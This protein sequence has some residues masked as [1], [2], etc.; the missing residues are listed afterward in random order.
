MLQEHTG[1]R[2]ACGLASASPS[3]GKDFL[4]CGGEA[5]PVCGDGSPGFP[6]VSV[7]GRRVHRGQW[8]LGSCLL[9]ALVGI[10]KEWPNVW[11][12]T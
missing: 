5:G 4:G 11:A 1:T 3:P 10:S 8:V 9:L 2:L 12:Y 7:T 6:E